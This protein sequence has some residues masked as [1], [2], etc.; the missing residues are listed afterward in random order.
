MLPLRRPLCACLDV[1]E[2]AARVLDLVRDGLE[3]GHRLAAVDQPVV[4]PG[5]R[6]SGNAQE[7]K[8]RRVRD[9]AIKTMHNI[10]PKTFFYKHNFLS[11]PPKEMMI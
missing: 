10:S 8:K 5:V 9:T 7:A 2:E 4:V 3:K 11:P 6:E 1:E